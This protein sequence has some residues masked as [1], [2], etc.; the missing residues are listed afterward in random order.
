MCC[1]C[2]HE[3]HESLQTLEPTQEVSAEVLEKSLD[4]QSLES[5][6]SQG[7]DKINAVNV[8]DKK[9]TDSNSGSSSSV[10]RL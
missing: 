6:G 7:E 4:P 8:A 1:S 3:A 2:R 5:S 9:E 10:A